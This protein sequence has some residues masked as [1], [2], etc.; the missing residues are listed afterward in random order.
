MY[1]RKGQDCGT[2]FNLF[3][4][5]INVCLL[6]RNV[7]LTF[8]GDETMTAVPPALVG[9]CRGRE[10]GEEM[11]LLLFLCG[12]SSGSHMGMVLVPFPARAGHP[13]APNAPGAQELGQRRH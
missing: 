3:S 4:H 2:S 7:Q 8:D 1:G 6:V 13:I 9:T 5:Y 11:W 10:G 12:G